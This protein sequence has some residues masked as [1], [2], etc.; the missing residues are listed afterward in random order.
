MAPAAVDGRSPSKAPPQAWIQCMGGPIARRQN[1]RAWT[2]F[3]A[4]ESLRQHRRAEIAAMEAY[5]GWAVSRKPS[6][7][8]CRGGECGEI[9]D[10]GS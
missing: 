6:R 1:Q 10:Y 2:S 5:S 8:E 4:D 9:H 3:A 7:G